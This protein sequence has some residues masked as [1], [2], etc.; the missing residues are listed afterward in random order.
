MEPIIKEILDFATVN[1][2]IIR[3]IKVLANK[4]LLIQIMFF[5]VR[6][7]ILN[8][9]IALKNKITYQQRFIDFPQ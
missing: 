7:L 3:N 5:K 9:Y 6:F 8:Q 1:N 4:I 2:S